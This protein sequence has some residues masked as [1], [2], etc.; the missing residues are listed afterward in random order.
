MYRDYRNPPGQ[1]DQYELSTTY[2]HVYAAK[3][4]FV[5]LFQNLVMWTKSII[6]W[7]IPDM[8]KYLRRLMQRENYI[9]N[10]VIMHHE[11][12]RARKVGEGGRL[13]ESFLRHTRKPGNDDSAH[14][15]NKL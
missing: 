9:T 8:P 15:T 1:A 7:S 10:E 5:V 4:I 6:A 11:L 14:E 2:W 12:E 13:F 3:F